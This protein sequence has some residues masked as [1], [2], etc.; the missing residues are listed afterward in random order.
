MKSSAFLDALVAA[1]QSTERIFKKIGG[2]EIEFFIQP[3]TIFDVEDPEN[4]SRVRVLFDENATD[5]KSDWLPVLNNGKG[6]ISSQYLGSKCLVGAVS[7]NTDNAIVFGWI[8]DTTS[9]QVI[10]AAPVM[11]PIIDVSDISNI[12]DPG[13]ECNKDNEGRAYI[14]SGN[15][16]QDFKVCIRRNNRQN[17][18]DADVWEWKNLT[19]GL[20]VEKET[21]PKQAE[22]SSTVHDQKPLPKCKQELEG[23]LIQ[24]TED[25]DFRQVPMVCKKDENK[26]WAWVPTSAPPIY[27]KSLLPKC[28][29][30]IHGQ[31]AAVDDG[32][33]SEF[34]ICVRFDKNMMWVKYGTR[35]P[36]AY[37]NKT[38]PP[39]KSTILKTVKEN[40]NLAIKPAQQASAATQSPVLASSKL[41]QAAFQQA[42]AGAVPGFLNNAISAAVGAVSAL[43]AFN[44]GEKIAQQIGSRILAEQGINIGQ[45]SAVLASGDLGT[46][47]NLLSALGPQAEKIIREGNVNIGKILQ[48]AGTDALLTSFSSVP[49]Q[50]AGVMNSL[51]VGGPQGALDSAVQYGLDLV[52]APANELFSHAINGL[53]LNN[54]PAALASMLN[55]GAGGGLGDIVNNLTSG[56]DLGGVNIGALASQLASGSLGDVSKVFQDFSNLGS[57]T[58]LIPG[59][60]ASA[61]SIMGAIG[62]GGPLTMALPGGIGLSAATSL[63]GGANPLSSI[64]G[65]GGAF[66]ALG[67]LFGGG[68]SNPC[69]CLPSCRK[70]EHGV[71]SDGNR[72]LDPPGN[73]TLKN[74]NV[75]G[76]DILNNNSGCLAGEAGVKPTGIG[77]PL[78]P[79]NL[80]DFTAVIK[81]IP[82]V[83]ELSKKFEDALKG[84]AEGLDIGLEMIYSLEAIE[85]SFK[86][87]DNNVSIMELIERLG[88]LGS[89]NFMN[90]L[91]TDKK[92]GLL[93]KMTTDMVEHA[94]AIEDL[95]RMVRE[96]NAVKDGG[97]ANTAAT[98]AII[99]TKKNQNKIPKYFSKSRTEATIN[100]VKTILEGLSTLATLDPVLGV[101]FDNLK[102]R[103]DQSK[104]LNDSLSAKFNTNQ[105]TEDSLN[106][107]FQDFD[108]AGIRSLSN[109]QLDSN[110]FAT[111]LEQINN[112][113]ERAS[114]GEGSCS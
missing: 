25:R 59:L 95:H 74:T 44:S 108:T 67:G 3:A 90:N 112:E 33:N 86:I 20:I 113:Q 5:A 78:I 26:E 72:L 79:K 18:P 65:G 83:D 70:V 66:G 100:L 37:S 94:N 76:P 45:I 88:L 39:K 12:N 42:G 81:S 47:G 23:E 8:N 34:A 107:I 92:G 62:L 41:A 51:I 97:R 14:F 10:S 104:V 105:P 75:Y 73:L 1:E 103:N 49:P 60:P 89:K 19:R 93:G 61:S 98:P 71:D 111:L 106:S 7:G 13:V 80:L 77:L 110:E 27:I 40:P 52:P 43:P 96:L 84:G 69:P 2:L 11:V 28:T 21:D 6:K 29:E 15:V 24:F 64:L 82:R 9:N 54:A 91:I 109:N 46:A 85:K 48:T 57:L 30:K 16:S 36:I 53:D 99:L 31:T 56:I 38:A 58:S 101:P 32:N 102:T 68:G 35:T 55:A 114:R 4:L 63:L 87:A 50:I 17:G 22:D